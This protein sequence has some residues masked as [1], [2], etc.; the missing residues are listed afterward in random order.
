MFY[1]QGAPIELLSD[2]DTIF[3]GWRFAAFAAHWGVA[4]RFR[5]AYTPSG[6]G[7]LVRNHHTLRVIIT[8]KYCSIDET[9]HL[10]KVTPQDRTMVTEAPA[11][12]ETVCNLNRNSMSLT[13]HLMMT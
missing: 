11:S 2:N 4:L 13:P 9:V 1:E 7:I 5:V 6:N 12:D 10:Y 8:R 3:R